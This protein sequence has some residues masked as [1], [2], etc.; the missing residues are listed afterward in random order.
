MIIHFTLESSANPPASQCQTVTSI[1][2]NMIN[3][4]NTEHLAIMEVIAKHN[5]LSTTCKLS[6]L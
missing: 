2:I 1:I 5:P 3:I 4:Q 6:N